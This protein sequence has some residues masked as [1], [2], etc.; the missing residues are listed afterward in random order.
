MQTICD[1]NG[2]QIRLRV[3]DDLSQ[4]ASLRRPWENKTVNPDVDIDFYEQI[5]LKRKGVHKPIIILVEMGDDLVDLLIGRCQQGYAECK[6]GYYRLFSCSFRE[7]VFVGQSLQG[8]YSAK[9]IEAILGLMWQMTTSGQADVIR[10]CNVGCESGLHS[11]CSRLGWNIPHNRQALH[12]HWMA[13]LP[14]SLEQYLNERGAST[15]QDLRKKQKRF[16]RD[17]NDRAHY[18][19]YRTRAEIGAFCGG[20]EQVARGSYQRALGAGFLND[21]EAIQSLEVASA[22]GW[23]RGTVLYVD[24][25][26][27]AFVSGYVLRD[28][29]YLIW[30]GHTKEYEYYGIGL[31]I[32][33]KL[34]EDVL[35]EGVKWVDFGIGSGTHKARLGTGNQ[36]ETDWWIYGRNWHG[37]QA[38][39]VN[40]GLGRVYGLFKRAFKGTKVEA[41][42]KRAWRGRIASRLRGSE[43]VKT[44][45]QVA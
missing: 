30:T 4:I 27:V 38:A 45:S 12:D 10:I 17:V 29:I 21:Q 2:I 34:F 37:F 36:Q 25:V 40:N 9:V 44:G 13:K 39:V 41:A 42:I 35:A 7:I 1:D 32:H 28:T 6:M 24:K 8:L 31:L 16:Q 22:K 14:E 33:L 11:G 43:D 20:A 23:W 26:P 18:I 15:R 3:I 19:T 5:V